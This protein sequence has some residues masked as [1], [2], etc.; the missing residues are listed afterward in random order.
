MDLLR[1]VLDEEGRQCSPSL[2]EGLK[3]FMIDIDGTIGE[4]IA[5][6]EPW[7][8]GDAEFYP[9]ALEMINKWHAQGH[10]IT[11]FSSRTEE[12]REVTEDWLDKCGFL[13]HGVLLEKPRGGNYHWIDNHHVRATQFNTRFTELISKTRVVEV[14]DDD[15]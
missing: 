8:M 6:E 9:D 3:N 10:I 11:F 15:D 5:N 4:D 12:H 13:Y 7:R 1:T 14:F 2:A